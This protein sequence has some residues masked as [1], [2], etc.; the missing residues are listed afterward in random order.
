[1]K[2]QKR[3]EPEFLEQFKFKWTPSSSANRYSNQSDSQNRISSSSGMK[4]GDEILDIISTEL[5]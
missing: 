2:T 3:S 5:T 1:M 4:F